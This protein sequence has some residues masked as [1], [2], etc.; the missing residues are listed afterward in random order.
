MHFEN[1]SDYK[2]T[3]LTVL[4]ASKN[5]EVKQKITRANPLSAMWKF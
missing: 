5:T 3:T 4:Y 1:N 2:A